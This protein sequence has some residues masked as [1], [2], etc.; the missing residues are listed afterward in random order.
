[1]PQTI[2]HLNNQ[3]LNKHSIVPRKH[4]YNHIPCMHKLDRSL[5]WILRLWEIMAP[6]MMLVETTNEV[7]EQQLRSYS[8]HKIWGTPHQI[9][10]LTRTLITIN[11]HL[12]VEWTEII[13]SS[14]SPK[15]VIKPTKINNNQLPTITFLQQQPNLQDNKLGES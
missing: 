1:M 8:F 13:L 7:I 2:D 10:H 4:Q 15:I 9:I 3:W 5:D 12:Q 6:I 11:K 14:Q